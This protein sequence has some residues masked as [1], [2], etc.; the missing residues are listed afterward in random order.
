MIKTIEWLCKFKIT[1]KKRE[2]EIASQLL[3]EKPKKD[4]KLVLVQEEIG[5]NF[6]PSLRK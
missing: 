1:E 4:D 2:H 6:N 5:L 3:G